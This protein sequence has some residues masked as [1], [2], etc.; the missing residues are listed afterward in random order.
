MS[1]TTRRD[2]IRQGGFLGLSLLTA[3]LARAG[4]SCGLTPAQTEGPFYPV[5]DQLDKD[6]DLTRLAGSTQAAAGQVVVITGQVRTADC[7]PLAGA[8]VEIWQACS[9]GRYNHPDDSS[10]APLDSNFQ[11]WGRTHTDAGGMYSFRTIKPGAYPASADWIRPPH[12]HFKIAAP[13]F[14]SLTTQM[15]FAGDPLN[16]R[17]RILR[18]LSPAQRQLVVPEFVP[19]AG[20]AGVLSG[21][22]DIVLGRLGA[23]GVTPELD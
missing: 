4:E 17:D 20:S 5:A 8:M 10:S 19:L 23:A 6:A 2:I 1:A 21:R 22:F 12:V 15:Y 16:A 7:A 18:S 9:S 3:G 13:G 11:Y 14:R